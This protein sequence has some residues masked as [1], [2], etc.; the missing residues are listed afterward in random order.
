MKS[1]LGAK[2]KGRFPATDPVQVD[3][4]VAEV[5]AVPEESTSHT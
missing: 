5:E 2:V 1:E 4:V 3:A